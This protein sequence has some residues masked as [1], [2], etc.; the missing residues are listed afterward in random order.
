MSVRCTSVGVGRLVAW[1]VVGVAVAAPAGPIDPPAGPVGPTMKPLSEIEPR[2]P[3][4]AE[5]TPGDADSV[6]RV[7]R[8]G[9]Y[10]LTGNLAGEA[11]KH[12]IEIA[13]SN[14]TIDL[15]GFT[16]QG[17][18]DAKS[19]IVVEADYGAITVRNGTVQQFGEWGILLRVP[20]GGASGFR[21]EGVA[22]VANGRDGI[23]TGKGA[24]VVDCQAAS[25]LD[26][27]IDVA[28]GSTVERCVT[29]LNASEG[30][31]ILGDGVI[32]GCTSRRNETGFYAS[33]GSRISDSTST[34]NNKHGAELFGASFVNCT[35]MHNGENGVVMYGG[36]VIGSRVEQNVKNGVVIRSSA[37][38]V[39]ESNCSRNGANGNIG[40]AILLEVGSRCLIRNNDVSSTHYGV[41][42][43][44]SG[45]TIVGNV[46][47]DCNNGSFLIVGGNNV[48]PVVGAIGVSTTPLANMAF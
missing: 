19:G 14:V 18:A 1:L 45:N 16:V 22:A 42:V 23:A 2:T 43:N 8:P 39:V 11:F 25:N 7:T 5:T 30:I 47:M 36:E 32:R 15:G 33:Y 34:Q 28:S 26:D 40:H 44:T 4:S 48:G 27:G 31:S 20:Q 9:S 10:Y 29:E 6:Y 21:V 35:S 12:A 38:R 37:A 24:V 3:L 41:K 13:A 17:V 46:A